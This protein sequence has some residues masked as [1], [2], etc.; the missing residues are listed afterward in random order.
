MDILCTATRCPAA[1]SRRSRNSRAWRYVWSGIRRD[2]DSRA[3]VLASESEE[4][5]YE[6]LQYSDSDSEPD[7]RPVV[8]P[9]PSA[10]PVTGESYCTCDSQAEPS[11]NPRLRGFHRIKDC[12]CGEEDQDFDWV[13]DDS[14]RSTA[15]LMTC[16]NRKVNFHTEYSCGTAAI[17]GSKELADGQH[18]WEIKMTS[19]VYGTDMMVGIGTCDVNLDKYR[20]TFCS[21]LGKDDDSWG[22]SYTGLLHHK[23]DKVTFSSR[24]GQGSIIGVH[25]DTWHGT[26]TF[27]KNRKCIG[28]AATELQNKHFYPMACSTAAKSSMKVIR[29]CFTPTSLQ[30]LCCARLR[31]LLPECPDTLSVLPLPPGLRHLL[32]NKL[33][34]VLRLNNGLLGAPGGGGLGSDLPPTPPLAGAL[35]SESDDSEGCSSDPEA[36]QRKRCRWT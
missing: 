31:K 7:Y 33:G 22:L 4:W 18:F 21:L 20:H 16:D 15:T 8:P 34:W 14:N 2:S 35:S 5:G 13:W 1:M 27:F 19:P 10:V 32:H 6:R 24:F 28:V 9:V 23:G 12:H 11:Y 29:S 25:L 3:L 30:Y 17:R 26:L 36:C